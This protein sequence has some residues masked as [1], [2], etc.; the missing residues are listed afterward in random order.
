MEV[1]TAMREVL[2]HIGRRLLRQHLDH[3]GLKTEESPQASQRAACPAGVLPTSGE[4]R[5]S[6]LRFD[7]YSIP[8]LV[9]LTQPVQDLTTETG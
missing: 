1:L 7:L 4:L 6:D 5:Q 9:V 3:P 2:Q 8:G